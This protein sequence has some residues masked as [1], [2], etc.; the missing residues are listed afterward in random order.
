MATFTIFED[1]NLMA[2]GRSVMHAIIIGVEWYPD[3]EVVLNDLS[4]PAH[5][6]RAIASWLLDCKS[7]DDYDDYDDEYPLASLSLLITEANPKQ[8][9]HPKI[10]TLVPELADSTNVKSAISEWF[11][12]SDKNEEDM[13]LFYFCGHGVSNGLG[14]Q[15]LLLSDY[16]RDKLNPMDGAIDFKSFE[17]G[18]KTCAASRQLYFVDACRNTA[19]IAK[20]TQQ[21]G[22]PMVSS[23]INRAYQSNVQPAIYYATVEG[24]KAYSKKDQVSFFTDAL[25]RGLRGGGSDNREADGRWRISTTDLFKSI[26]FSINHRNPDHDLLPQAKFSMFY[27]HILDDEPEAHVLVCCN[28]GQDNDKAKMECLSNGKVTDFRNILT[29]EWWEI[30]KIPGQY[31]FKA[32]ISASTG[33]CDGVYISPPYKKVNVWVSP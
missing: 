4:S 28:N 32:F 14:S 27:F 12:K 24:E 30:F 1:Q 33:Q 29:P 6:A 11:Q 10:T 19:H 26:H 8:F 22:L 5:S 16:G 25:I 21:A 13:T 23:N 9:Q 15:S 7:Y 31:D 3:A 17:R 2:S 18:M 20:N